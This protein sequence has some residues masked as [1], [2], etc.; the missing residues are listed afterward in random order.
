MGEVVRKLGKCSF[1]GM[2]G[3]RAGVGYQDSKA[4]IMCQSGWCGKN[5]IVKM[6]PENKSYL[7]GIMITIKKQC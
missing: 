7:T 4:I 1:L 6:N 5:S 3:T 2:G